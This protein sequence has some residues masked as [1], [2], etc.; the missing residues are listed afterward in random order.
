MGFSK[1]HLCWVVLVSCLNLIANN[2][3]QGFHRILPEYQ[4][5]SAAAV[6]QTYRTAYHFQPRMHYMNDPNAPTYF[7]GIYHLFYQYNPYGSTWGNIVWGHSYS[8]DLINWI[9]LETAIYPSEPF[10]INGTWSGSATILPGNKP[11]IFYTGL[12]T[13]NRQ[14][15]NVAFPKNLSDPLL[16]EWV[17]PSYNPVIVPTKN[18]NASAFRDPTTAWVGTDREWR[19]AIGHKRN[20]RGRVELYKSKDFKTWTKSKHAL[21]SVENSGMLECPDL[22]PV[23]LKG[24]EGLDASVHGAHVKYVLKS[25][26]DLTRFDY[27]TVGQYFPKKEIYIPDNTSPDNSTGLRLDYGNFYASK[28]FFDEKKKRRVLWGWANE[29]TTKIDDVKKGWAGIQTIP[30]SLWLDASGKQLVQWPVEEIE[31]LRGDAIQL[32]NV[33]LAPEALIEVKGITSTQADFE[34]TF[35]LPSLDNAEPFDPTW[36][37]AEKVCGKKD[38]TIQGGLG[39]FGLLTLASK[40]IEEYTAIFFHVFKTQNKPVVLMCAGGKMSS[41]R[42]D[43]YEPSYGGFAEVDIVNGDIS[44]RSLVDHSVVESFGAGGKICITSRVYPT[45]ATGVNA[46]T[47]LFNNGTAPVTVRNLGG[48][49]MKKPLMN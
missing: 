34:V 32:S 13:E 3:V 46:H 44:L 15:Q 36:V 43:L 24:K 21:H 49:N 1:P 31:T 39:P 22:F 5:L 6:D 7:N 25:S 33:A 8:T 27:Y 40:N 18:M 11:V 35:T 12:D 20:A 17:K 14:V 42:T 30:R 9:A 26:L 28:T 23:L 10:D 2:R 47:F 41:L 29:S 37:D 38:S 16:R 19:V 4:S 48:W 45:M